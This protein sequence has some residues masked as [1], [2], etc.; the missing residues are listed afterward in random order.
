M[1]CLAPAIHLITDWDHSIHVMR[2][3][4]FLEVLQLKIWLVKVIFE[5]ILNLLP[6]SGKYAS[7]TSH[8]HDA[9]CLRSVSFTL[10]ALNRIFTLSLS[11]SFLSRL[12][13]SSTSQLGAQ[14]VCCVQ[15]QMFS[16]AYNSSSDTGMLSELLR[17]HFDS[18][19]L[20]KEILGCSSPCSG[21]WVC[22]TSI[23]NLCYIF[24]FFFAWVPA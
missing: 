24:Q 9:E 15:E 20:P 12:V 22:T 6:L 4:R 10:V 23:G 5:V 3:W 1:L 13:H 7:V 8:K 19:F 21:S 16:L 2:I 18:S 17:S 14:W 11:S